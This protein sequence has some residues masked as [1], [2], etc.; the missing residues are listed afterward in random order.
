MTLLNPREVHVFVYTYMDGIGA[1]L[2]RDLKIAAKDVKCKVELAKEGLAALDARIDARHVVVDCART[3]TR[4][5]HSVLSAADHATINT[6]I[7]DDALNAD[8]FRE[9]H[10]ASTLVEPHRHGVDI[11]GRLTIKGHTH[12]VHMKLV[13]SGDHYA[14]TVQLRL[15]DYGIKPFS[16]WLGLFHIKPEV[17]LEVSLPIDMVAHD[18]GAAGKPI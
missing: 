2:G 14:G 9:I 10:F 18:Y 12:Q 13:R 15:A 1:M 7:Q 3:G 16:K 5:D 4:D 11:T 8:S 6:H 17:M